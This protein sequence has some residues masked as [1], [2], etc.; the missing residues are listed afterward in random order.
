M[1]VDIL[2]MTFVARQQ[3]RIAWRVSFDNHVAMYRCVEC[4]LPLMQAPVTVGVKTST[5]M[6]LRFGPSNCIGCGRPLEQYHGDLPCR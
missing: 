5:P 1:V 2:T 4:M 6:A 3:P